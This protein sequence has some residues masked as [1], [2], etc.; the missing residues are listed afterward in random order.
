MEKWEEECHDRNRLRQGS[1]LSSLLCSL[2]LASL[3][4]RHLAPLLQAS[5]LAWSDVSACAA[6]SAASDHP[7]LS[8]L[9]LAAGAFL[10]FSL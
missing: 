1:S 9:A 8:A 4:R 7:H 10:F 5:G 2:Y 6:A 3:E